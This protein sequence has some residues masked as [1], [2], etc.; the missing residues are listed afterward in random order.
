MSCSVT[1]NP[2]ISHLV[3]THNVN[4]SGSLT[5]PDTDRTDIGTWGRDPKLDVQ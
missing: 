5:R 4:I 1:A 3:W 2:P